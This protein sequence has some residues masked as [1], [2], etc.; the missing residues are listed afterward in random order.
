M[1]RQIWVWLAVSAIS[2]FAVYAAY[3]Y[4]AGPKIVFVPVSQGDLVQTIVA[5][6]HVQNPNRIDISSQITSTVMFALVFDTS[7]LFHTLLLASL[8]GLVSAFAR[9]DPVVAIKA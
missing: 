3:R 6:G 7:L 8:T 9:L 1:R 5:S 2:I 4:W